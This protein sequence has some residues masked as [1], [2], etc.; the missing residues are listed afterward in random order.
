MHGFGRWDIQ[1]CRLE[2]HKEALSALE[3]GS[4]TAFPFGKAQALAVGPLYRPR[5]PPPLP[6]TPPLA[7]EDGDP[8]EQGSVIS[9]STANVSG[10]ET[11]PED[12]EENENM[13]D[14]SDEEA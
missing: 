14:S 3:P 8:E 1:W 11:E 6:V 12:P 10:G 13:N 2:T 4:V 5:D 7:L 9:G